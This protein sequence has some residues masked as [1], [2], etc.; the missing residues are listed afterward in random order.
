MLVDFYHFI[1]SNG[2]LYWIQRIAIDFA[3][4]FFGIFFVLMASLRPRFP[5][6]DF[7]WTWVVFSIDIICIRTLLI[8]Y[9]GIARYN[10]LGVLCWLSLTLAGAFTLGVLI[11]ERF[12][13][14]HLSFDERAHNVS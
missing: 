12:S 3:A 14:E 6:M 1:D 13:G 4:A 5:S 11:Y 10:I 9:H 2:S 7:G 8:F